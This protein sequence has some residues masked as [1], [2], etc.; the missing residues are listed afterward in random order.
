M[1]CLTSSHAQRA[2]ALSGQPAVRPTGRGRRRLTPDV[3]NRIHTVGNHDRNAQPCNDLDRAAARCAR[4]PPQR[5]PGSGSCPARSSC[6]AGQTPWSSRNRPST[7]SCRYP[8]DIRH[9]GWWDG[10]A[11][12]G[13]PFGST[14]IA[15]H[16]D[17]RLQG[18]GFFA[19]LLFVQVGDLITVRSDGTP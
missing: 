19:E 3:G 8:A 6:R 16:V 15:G 12:A 13:D 11:Y 10:S 2:P 9:V 14:V 4:A 5:A 17:S 18:L 1:L 7:A